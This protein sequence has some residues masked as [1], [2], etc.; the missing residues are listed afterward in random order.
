MRDGF[1]C[2]LARNLLEE[3]GASPEK[4]KPRRRPGHDRAKATE[5]NGPRAPFSRPPPEHTARANV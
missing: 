1:P 2:L 3:S 4:E 5:V